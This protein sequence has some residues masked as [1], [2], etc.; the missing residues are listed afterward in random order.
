MIEPVL[1]KIKSEIRAENLDLLGF[2]QAFKNYF[3]TPGTAEKLQHY[4]LL[5]I[6]DCNTRSPITYDD[7]YYYYKLPREEMESIIECV[8]NNNRFETFELICIRKWN[9][10][11]FLS[12]EIPMMF[13][14]LRS[15]HVTGIF[16][17][18]EFFHGSAPI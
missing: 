11:T 2:V 8:K 6:T 14:N 7:Y 15:V 10:S 4:P 9:H 3:L 13:L 17:N 12:N 1:F 18:L 16:G 5:R